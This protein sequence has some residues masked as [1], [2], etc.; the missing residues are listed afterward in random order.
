VRDE[1]CEI[2]EIFLLMGIHP[3]VDALFNFRGNF[4]DETILSVPGT[5]VFRPGLII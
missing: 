3:R 5:A 4:H 1:L 2:A